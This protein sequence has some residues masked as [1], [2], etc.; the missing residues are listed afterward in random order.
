MWIWFLLH[1]F[2]I[3]TKNL[4]SLFLPSLFIFHFPFIPSLNWNK[5]WAYPKI[6]GFCNNLCYQKGATWLK[7]DEKVGELSPTSSI[8]VCL[9]TSSPSPPTNSKLDFPSIIWK[10]KD[11]DVSLGACLLIGLNGQGNLFVWKRG[12][13]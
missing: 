1:I 12:N 8:K 10:R 13:A 4:L 7:L 6:V 3:T 9:E 11:L 2:F 5:S